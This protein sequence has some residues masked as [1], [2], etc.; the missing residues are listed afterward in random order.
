LEEGVQLVE[1]LSLSGLM[2]IAL[3]SLSEAA[4]GVLSS[5]PSWLRSFVV[6]GVVGGVGAVLLFAP[7]VFMASL[8]VALLEDSGLLPRIAVRSHRLFSI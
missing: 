5:A 7:L 4:E 2:G 3:S 6:E 8:L 1:S